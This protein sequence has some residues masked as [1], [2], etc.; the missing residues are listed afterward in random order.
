M[1]NNYE[2]TSFTVNHLMPCKEHNGWKI[3]HDI[4]LKK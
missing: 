2:E 1:F 4:R 3:I